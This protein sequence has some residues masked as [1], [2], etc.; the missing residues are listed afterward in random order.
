MDSTLRQAIADACREH[1]RLMAEGARVPLERRQGA[2]TRREAP[3]GDLNGGG[4]KTHWSSSLRP[5][6][7]LLTRTTRTSAILELGTIG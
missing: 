5:P 2:Y 6:G 4:R 7:Y 3:L 1:D